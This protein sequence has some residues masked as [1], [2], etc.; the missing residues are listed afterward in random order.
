[1]IFRH[2]LIDV[3]ESNAFIIGCEETRE[4]LLVD[5]A[6]W[7]PRIP[8]FLEE[9]KL[10]ITTIFITH[11]HY[12]HSGGLA[13][14]I[15]ATRATAYSGNGRAGGM[16]VQHA[17]HGQVLTVGNIKGTV[18]ATPG[19]TPDGISLALPGM[20]FTGDALFSGSVGGTSSRS[21]AEEQIEAIRK[22]ILTL[23]GDY[24]IH[25]GHG[26]SSTAAVERRFNPFF[27]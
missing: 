5:V 22:H 10:R 26:P 18:L 8:A 9:H 27:N 17:K 13:Q 15:A 16:R 14:A 6:E 12:D 3:N 1:M 25:T 11:N 24:E 23:P 19:H 21:Q 7:D 2:F 20:V 4:T